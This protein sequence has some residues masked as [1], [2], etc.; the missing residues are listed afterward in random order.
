[1]KSLAQEPKQETDI[2]VGHYCER[3]RRTEKNGTHKR[4]Q[5]PSVRRYLSRYWGCCISAFTVLTAAREPSVR[6]TDLPT[7]HG[8][9]AGTRP[10]YLP[11]W[12]AAS[13]LRAAAGSCLPPKPRPS[14]TQLTWKREMTLTAKRSL[15]TARK[16]SW[17]ATTPFIFTKAQ[18]NSLY[19]S[20]QFLFKT[21]GAVVSV[22]NYNNGS[23][24]LR[25]NVTCVRNI[26]F[27]I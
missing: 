1:M 2:I 15:D 13:S 4:H 14:K 20:S 17:T 24:R 26:Y 9:T 27:I 16:F 23:W 11:F 18:G 21:A 8:Y 10:R 7:Q 12:P 25:C 3:T 22:S 6:N 5:I 19:S